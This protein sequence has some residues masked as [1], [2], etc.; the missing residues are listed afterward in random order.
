MQSNTERITAYRPKLLALFKRIYAQKL[1]AL[2][3]R[4]HGNLHLGQVL[5]TGKDLAISDYS[6]DPTL[7]YSERRLKRS[8]LIDI[9][10]MVLSFHKVVFDGFMCD[11]QLQESERTSLQP[12]AALWAHY[13][14]GIFVSGYMETVKDSRLLP[15]DPR[16][17]EMMW[18]IYLLQR[19]IATFNDSLR[20]DPQRLIISLTLIRNVLREQPTVASL[21]V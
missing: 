9:A 4:I 13:I 14:S 7:S 20:N 18:Q 17:L 1:D 15:S 19:A 5:L 16:D 10:T 11:P 8:P 21:A 6:G 12:F 3:I 2:K